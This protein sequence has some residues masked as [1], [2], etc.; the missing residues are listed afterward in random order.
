MMAACGLGSDDEEVLKKDQRL[1]KNKP[2]TGSLGDTKKKVLT[3]SSQRTEAPDGLPPLSLPFVIVD[4]ACQSVEP[5]TLIPLTVSNSCRSLVMLGDPCQ[6]PATVKHDPDSVLAV[7]LM[8]RLAA[9]LPQP[10]VNVQ[11]DASD[12][13]SRYID[14][15]PVKH[16]RS[17]MQALEG[18]GRRSSTVYRKRF[19][20]ALLL[21]IQYRM[22]PSIAAFAS[23]MFYDGSLTTPTLLASYRPFPRIFQESM[24]VADKE[25][26]VRFVNVGGRCNERRGEKEKAYTGTLFSPNAAEIAEESTTYQNEAEAQHV[27]S[28]IK[29]LLQKQDPNDPFTTKSVGVVTPYNGQ[30]HLIKQMIAKD[31][32][33]RTLFSS[34]PSNT[35]AIEVKSVDGY[36]GRE[37]DVIIFSAVR[38]NRRGNIGFL[39]DW[40]RLNVAM[41][42]AR[43]GL[44]VVGDLETL[45]EGDKHWAAFGKW[46]RSSRCVVDTPTG[47]P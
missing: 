14:A 5:A 2:K 29:E 40:R 37:R 41:T 30:V 6:L 33:L 13:D 4:E 28:L 36:Q 12:K 26:G 25:M 32:E 11:V 46:C 9:T 8:E 27:V 22:H 38:S 44:V 7:S 42:R 34:N 1:N 45:V 18:R 31:E 19:A 47:S 43:N 21:S 3:Q 17:L 24:P 39:R 10:S 15:L 23:S 20:G 16:A 35:A